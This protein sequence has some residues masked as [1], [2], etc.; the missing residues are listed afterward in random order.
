MSPFPLGILAASGAG[1]AGTYELLETT[2]LTSSASSVSFTGLGAYTEYK[3]LQ[4]RMVAQNSGSSPDSIIATFNSDTANNYATHR[5]FG[6]GSSV[7][8]DDF[9]N[10]ANI[11][12]GLSND[13]NPTDAF[14]ASVLDI[15]D[16][17]S[18]SKNTTTRALYGTSEPT[19]P[20][21]ALTS[22]LYNSTN[23][24]TS[25]EFANGGGTNF[26]TGSR[27]SLYGIK[28]A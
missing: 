18:T 27:F 2:V 11:F 15:L 13:P 8:S 6:T 16:F 24:I 7:I 23:A 25:I 17:S 3:H 21:I 9:I 10:R 4:I 26:A 1:V 20:Q 22:G 12:C 5:L 14:G 19:S 28:A